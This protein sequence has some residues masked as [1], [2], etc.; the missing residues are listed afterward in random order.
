M[1]QI[2]T[3]WKVGLFVA[4]CL[5]VLGG[6]LIKFSKG[7]SLSGTYELRVRTVNVGGIK[8]NALVFMAGVPVGVVRDVVLSNDGKSVVI[9]L[10]I[11]QRYQIY[12]DAIFTIESQGFLGDQYVSIAPTKNL[13]PLLKE[14][15]EVVCH[16]PF[17]IQ[18][19]A[20]SALS[21][22]QRVDKAVEKIDIAVTR[23]DRTLLAEETLTNLT[24]AIANVRKVS[25]QLIGVAEDVKAVS[26]KA[27]AVAGKAGALTDK[28]HDTLDRVDLLIATNT[29][30]VGNA[31]SNLLSFSKQLNTVGDE[32]RLTIS[33]NRPEFTAAI[34]NLET[35][36]VLATNLLNDLHTGK[37]LAGTVL[38]D[39]QLKGQFQLLVSNLN[40]LGQTY[41]A[42]G[43]NLNKY[44]LFYKPKLVKT[45]T[46][47]SPP[48]GRRPN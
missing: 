1:S 32:L 5:A 17:N 36:T 45:N 20:R 9:F 27:K 8:Q 46:A 39:E 41:G 3:E 14:G 48:V 16:E 38:K 35:A 42:L 31:V 33:T 2:R 13:P 6:L 24:A 43:S 10:N 47:A 4:I 21:L 25:D 37:G 22:I 30:P 29:A 15:E 11:Q 34:K 44:G 23:V 7:V 12:H 26:E 40:L 28:A 19:A 18:E